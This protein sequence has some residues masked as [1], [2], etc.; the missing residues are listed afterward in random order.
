MNF[1]TDSDIGRASKVW[2]SLIP[3]ALITLNIFFF[4]PFN[5]YYGNIGEFGS[6]LLSII[7]DFLIP[8]LSLLVIATIIGVML[9]AG[10]HRRYVSI[11]FILGVLLWLQGNLILWDYELFGTGDIDWTID[12]WRGWVDLGIWVVLI[13]L[14]LILYKRFYPVARSACGALVTLQAILV[15][16]N[17]TQKTEVWQSGYNA[18]STPE[19]IYQFSSKQN[20]IHVILDQLQASV[21]EEIIAE[22]TNYYRQAF[23]G[24]T[25]F[26][27]ALSAFPKTWMSMPDIFGG[28]V[29]QNDV[30][31][32]QFMDSVYQAKT[33]PNVLYERG[34]DVDITA[35]VDWYN[36]GRHSNIYRI[37]VPYGVA[38]GEYDRIN[39]AY[40]MELV[41]FRH[42]PH[43]IK[44]F[45]HEKQFTS[46]L[47]DVKSVDALRHHS[48][49]AFLQ[50]LITNASV[51]RDKNVYKFFHF[52]TTNWPAVLNANC[53]YVDTTLPFTWDNIK[54]QARCSLSRFLEFIDKL[55][56]MGIYDSSLI[57]LNADH[58]Y[59][60]VPGSA[61]HIN[62]LNADSNLS[63]DFSIANK[64]YVAQ[65]IS[66]SA[67]F[68]AIK[69]PLSHGPMKASSAQVALSDIPATVCSIL[70]IQ[71]TFP[72]RSVFDV[73]PTEIRER[74]FNYYHELNHGADGYFQRIDE[75]SIK[76]NIYDR[77]SWKWLTV[78][79]PKG[80]LYS[81]NN[82]VFGTEEVVRFFR[83][84]WSGNEK[85]G[86]TGVTYTWAMGNSASLFLALPPSKVKLTANVKSP[87]DGGEQL[88]TVVVNGVEAGSWK[89]SA[90][91]AWERHS[92]VI[93]ANANRPAI[94][95]VE[96]V[97]SSHVVPSNTEP[98]SLA[99]LFASITLEPQ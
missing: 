57:V 27:D 90:R 64:E 11:L 5:L 89:N 76:G 93:D 77:L 54:I 31:I 95:N 38:S 36:K 94:S 65:I 12:V 69:P 8:G 85:D 58:G 79:Y 82:I 22:D 25:F 20:V 39:S 49:Q 7:Y 63:Q 33:L 19:A 70:Q 37:P 48:H 50:D 21:F 92:V 67:P 55:K 2:S 66:S 41:A 40:M 88:V 59:W 78:H 15:I 6:P 32:Q 4:G 18:T 62:L 72:G 83:S 23:D 1:Q 52:T 81:T 45:V 16:V 17:T 97:F 10:L 53:E 28:H 80:Q 61:R 56:T 9:P 42:M 74:R 99:L 68:L 46:T 24:F 35:H 3:A 86:K 87:F 43:F 60:R 47:F 84:G 26:N 73:D 91:W 96:F 14:S 13:A 34:Y 71:E 30:P 75:Y 29:Y 44:R 51:R 98:R